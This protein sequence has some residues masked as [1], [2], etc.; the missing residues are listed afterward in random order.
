MYGH[1]IRLYGIS[2]H[3][4]TLAKIVC[5]RV[6]AEIFR[7]LFGLRK[8]PVH[9]REIQRQT[10]FSIGA[11]RQDM[12]KLVKLDLVTR[13]KDGNRVYYAANE[14]HPL[15]IDI[16]QMVLKTVGLADML[17]EALSD[18][19]IQ[20][21]FVFGSLATGADRA[22]SDVDLMVI[23]DIGLRKVSDLLAGID[24][25]VGREVNPFILTPDEF[26]KRM[27]EKEHFV[28]SVMGAEK[29]F[30]VGSSDDLETMAR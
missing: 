23:G 15:T 7:V 10:G 20:A 30:I 29:I 17:R 4:N 21:A 19:G 24:D 16:R 1:G 18:K 22:A 14:N 8:E 3:M 12:E 27:R 11:V 28:S 25:R 13:R 2:E 26:A 9:L 6:R 5:S